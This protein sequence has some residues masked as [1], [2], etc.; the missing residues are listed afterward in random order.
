MDVNN[1]HPENHLHPFLLILNVFPLTNMGTNG[2][3]E[4]SVNQDEHTALGEW[5]LPSLRTRDLL[6]DSF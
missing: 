2:M 3:G 5:V 6:C 1:G 4:I